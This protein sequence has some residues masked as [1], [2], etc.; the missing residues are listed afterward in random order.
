MITLTQLDYFRRLA[1]TEH[2]TATAK[3]LFISQTALSSMIISLEKELGV[4]LFD[5]S[6]RSIRL[7]AAGRTYLSYVNQ[8]F[9]ALDNGRA[10]IKDLKDTRE[11]QVSIAAGSSLVWAPML[12][13]FRSRYP[14][15]IMKQENLTAEM[16]NL[17]L[18]EMTVDYVIAGIE[19]V[20]VEGICRE[21]IKDD[22]VYLCVPQNHP[23]AERESVTLDE[24]KGETFINLPPGTPWRDFCDQLFENAGLSVHY[25]L[26]CDYTLRGSLIASGFGVALTTSTGKSVDLLKPNRYIRVNDP[27][28]I[29]D[30]CLFWNPARYM[31]RTALIFKE[32]CIDFYKD[33][34]L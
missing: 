19:A 4:Q 15:T 33:A 7:N 23:F 1:A 21:H 34:E 8:V 3:E 24:I 18:K 22:G 16:H 32:F 5:R 17:A 13:A 2:I 29:R 27:H 25:G 10:A 11:Q 26:E 31:S 14:D 6:R 30:M 9:A 12:H 20:T 28:A